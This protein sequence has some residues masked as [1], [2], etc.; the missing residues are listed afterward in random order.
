[1]SADEGRATYH[2]GHWAGCRAVDGGGPGS[3]PR[4]LLDL[5][6]HGF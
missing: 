1:M 5:E 3:V 2:I 4:V 6:L